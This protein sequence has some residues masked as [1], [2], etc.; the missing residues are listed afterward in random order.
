MHAEFW[1]GNLLEGGHCFEGVVDNFICNMPYKIMLFCNMVCIS[2]DPCALL[3]N[4][5]KPKPI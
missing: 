3:V 1:W 4:P 5:L 2:I